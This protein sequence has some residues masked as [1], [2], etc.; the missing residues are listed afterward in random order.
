M[1]A[2]EFH[3]IPTGIYEE[4]SLLLGNVGAQAA[5]EA[6]GTTRLFYTLLGTVLPS[7]RARYVTFENG[8]QEETAGDPG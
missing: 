6:L 1:L 2:G 8:L 5:K 4:V 7:F 3:G